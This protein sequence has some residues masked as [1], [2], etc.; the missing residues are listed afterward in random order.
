MSKEDQNPENGYRGG[1]RKATN[2]CNGKVWGD[3]SYA[4]VV[5]EIRRRAGDRYEE[6]KEGEVP[7][8]LDRRVSDRKWLERGKMLVSLPHDRPCPNKLK[9]TVG[10]MSFYISVEK[11]DRPVDFEWIMEELDLNFKWTSE[12]K[13][14]SWQGKRVD[15]MYKESMEKEVRVRRRKGGPIIKGQQ[16][17]VRNNK[18]RPMHVNGELDLEKRRASGGDINESWSSSDF[19]MDEGQMAVLGLDRGECSNHNLLGKGPKKVIYD[20]PKVAS[21]GE[22]ML[23]NTDGLSSWA[24]ASHESPIINLKHATTVGCVSGSSKKLVVRHD[25][26]R[27]VSISNQ[28]GKVLSLPLR[29]PIQLP[30]TGLKGGLIRGKDLIAVPLAVE[31]DGDERRN[32]KIQRMPDTIMRFS[33]ASAL[34]LNQ[35]VGKENKIPKV[36]KAPW[37]LKEEIAK[38]IKAGVVLGFDFKGREKEMV[39]EIVRRI[40]AG[41]FGKLEGILPYNNN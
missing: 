5:T 7:L 21:V 38:V 4:E 12:K 28:E 23:S 19:E 2:G 18:K 3:L 29:G 17:Y 33:K 27:M 1:Q 26:Q 30:L 25:D 14:V 32:S 9:V 40:K 41:T 35:D 11:E 6:S 36:K 20:G 22:G 15:K 8:I 24:A 31:L 10:S 39:E 34:E 37:N 13:E 16:A